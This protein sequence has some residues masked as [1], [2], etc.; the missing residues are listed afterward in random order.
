MQRARLLLFYSEPTDGRA[1]LVPCKFNMKPSPRALFPLL[2][3]WQGKT[4][5]AARSP[6]RM[7]ACMRARGVGKGRATRS[8]RVSDSAL[9][10]EVL[11]FLRV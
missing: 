7:H 4:V 8:P 5:L 6:R 1:L 3:V 2:K 10:A 11:E 9:R